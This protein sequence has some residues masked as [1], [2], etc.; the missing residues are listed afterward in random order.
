[1]NS[2]DFVDYLV[3]RRTSELRRDNY[4]L[5]QVDGFVRVSL[6]GALFAELFASESAAEAWIAN[7]LDSHVR[8]KL[9]VEE[10]EKGKIA[11]AAIASRQK[12]QAFKPSNKKPGRKRK[13]P[14]AIVS[15]PRFCLERIEHD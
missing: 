4:H 3:G 5:S 13:K 9:A 15:Q 2:D 12:R 7:E 14:V 8:Y 10:R 11:A 6:D 1:M